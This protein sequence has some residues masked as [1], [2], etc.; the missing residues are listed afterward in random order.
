MPEYVKT[1][2]CPK[3]GA[4][5]SGKGHLC[6][7]NPDAGFYKCEFCKK[8]TDNVRHACKQ[9]MDSVEYICKKCGRLAAYDTLLCEPQPIDAD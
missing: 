6:H 7:P 3:C 1:F 8:E 2:K 5:A 9:M 4:N